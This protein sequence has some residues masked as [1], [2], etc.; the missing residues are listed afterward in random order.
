MNGN[1]A[2][3]FSEPGSL[4]KETLSA[5]VMVV[6][7]PCHQCKSGANLDIGTKYILQSQ[8]NQSKKRKNKIYWGGVNVH[9]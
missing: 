8:V 3:F 7:N 9:I 2:Y 6:A 5:D 4:N 1:I